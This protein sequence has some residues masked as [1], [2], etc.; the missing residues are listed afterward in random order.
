M[1][2]RNAVWAA[3]SG[4]ALPGALPGAL[5]SAVL[6]GVLATAPSMATPAHAAIDPE[7]PLDDA[8]WQESFV[9]EFDTL[10]LVGADG[11]GRWTTRYYWPRDVIINEELQYYVDPASAPWSPF[12]VE[13]GVLAIEARPTPDSMRDEVEGQSYVSGVLTTQTSFAQK[14][15]RFEAVARVPEGRGLWSAFWLLPSFESWPEGVAVLPEI[16]V[17]EHIGHE[18]NTFHTTLHTNQTGELTSHPYDHTGDDDLTQGFHRYSVVWT[19]ERVHWYLDREHV[20]SHPTPADFTRPVHFLL[21][22]AVG[23]TWPGA[24]DASTR[25]PARYLVDSVR[26]YV[27]DEDC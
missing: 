16:D 4:A 2:V 8:C 9:E 27:A 15:G 22:L 26:A 18:P 7:A 11:A 12:S 20:A 24:P 25:F 1:S 14:H 3:A 23:G 21:N 5:P 17:M 13:D 6:L 10:D 19:P